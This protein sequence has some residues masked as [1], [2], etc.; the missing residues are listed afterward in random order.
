MLPFFRGLTSLRRRS[1]PA[2]SLSRVLAWAQHC[3]GAQEAR[4]EGDHA[5]HLPHRPPDERPGNE[6]SGAVS[7]ALRPARSESDAGSSV[8]V[9]DRKVGCGFSCEKSVDLKK[10]EAAVEHVFFRLEGDPFI[11][12]P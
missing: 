7:G 9:E 4:G 1:N 10:G 12:N 6:P 2:E 8:E 3:D 5:R 11:L